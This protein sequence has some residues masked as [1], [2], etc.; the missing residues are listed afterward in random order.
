MKLG[1]RASECLGGQ[2]E[3]EAAEPEFLAFMG[4]DTEA[5]AVAADD[6]VGFGQLNDPGCVD[7][8]TDPIQRQFGHL[9]IFEPAP[10]RSTREAQNSAFPGVRA[11]GITSRMFG[12]PVRNISNRSNPSPKPACGTVP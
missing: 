6:G 7:V 9:A 2:G 12:T 1:L 3:V 4:E 10:R 11:K 5:H 8:L